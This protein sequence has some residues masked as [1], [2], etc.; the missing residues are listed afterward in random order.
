MNN[1]GLPGTGLGGLFYILLAL[2]MPLVQLYRVARGRSHPG[3][4]R[5]VAQQFLL[6]CG[7]LA[8]LALTTV[9]YRQVLGGPNPFGVSGTAVLL[10]PVVLAALLLTVLVLVLRV[11]ALVVG[12]VP[13][14]LAAPRRVADPVGR[15]D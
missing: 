8:S 14:P 2:L 7:V 1:A 13:A 6:S 5:Q 11:W 4:W 15:A 10:G 12:S 9:F 3:Q